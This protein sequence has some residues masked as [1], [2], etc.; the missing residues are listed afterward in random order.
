M[1]LD[2]ISLQ[3]QCL[4]YIICYLEL[5]PLDYLALL[6]AAIRQ[7]LLENLPPADI[8][9][10]EQSRFTEGLDTERIWI[11]HRHSLTRC[12]HGR[13]WLYWLHQEGSPSNFFKDYFFRMAYSLVLQDG[14]STYDKSTLITC[15]CTPVHR[16]LTHHMLH[17]KERVGTY[18]YWSF[19]D[20]IKKCP[21]TTPRRFQ[22]YNFKLHKFPEIKDQLKFLIML[23]PKLC[24]YYPTALRVPLDKCTRAVCDLLI[25]DTT[26]STTILFQHIKSLHFQLKKQ[27]KLHVRVPV[28]RRVQHFVH[29]EKRYTTPVFRFPHFNGI[30]ETILC[31]ALQV[32]E[33]LTIEV[34]TTEDLSIMLEMSVPLLWGT[35]LSQNSTPNMTITAQNLKEFTIIMSNKSESHICLSI[36]H[37]TL[38]HYLSTLFFQPHFNSL[39]LEGIIFRD[40]PHA[41][42]FGNILYTF[43]TSPTTHEQSLTCRSI[44]FQQLK[45]EDYKPMPLP[46]PVVSSEH[47]LKYKSL[48]FERMSLPQSVLTWLFQAS[49]L[50]LQALKLQLKPLTA[51]PTG[52]LLVLPAGIEKVHVQRLAL[53]TYVCQWYRSS[54]KDNQQSA[55]Q[56]KFDPGLCKTMHS[57]QQ[58]L[59]KNTLTNLDLNSSGLGYSSVLPYL[60]EG[61]LNQA[62]VGTLRELNL[63]NNYLQYETDQNL[64]ELF[65]A[66]FGLPQIQELSLNING[67][68]LNRHHFDIIHTSWTNKS[69]GLK[70]QNLNY[71]LPRQPPHYAKHVDKDKHVEDTKYIPEIM[72]MIASH[73][74]SDQEKVIRLRPLCSRHRGKARET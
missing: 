51:L 28:H 43:L 27:E 58:I 46:P 63:A 68:E 53:H 40:D 12:I 44:E 61:L 59:L 17:K 6:P 34:D 65:D 55:A 36:A 54:P 22:Q 74:P 41:H 31:P 52:P 57:L 70:L 64:V 42:A 35:A 14:D 18:H 4:I 56:C 33:K 32:L 24:H 29:Q 45:S 72:A 3:N 20:G 38:L 66:I 73:T 10:L 69:A 67:N 19:L 15:L 2:P 50:R 71:N 39:H 11:M 25:D 7:R 8:C 13:P 26:P 23:I 5:F 48:Q 21:I 16:G 1:A 62:A 47:S 9:R 49:Q 30:I 60:T 37:D